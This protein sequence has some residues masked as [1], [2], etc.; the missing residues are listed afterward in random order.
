[1]SGAQKSDSLARKSSLKGQQHQADSKSTPEDANETSNAK[2]AKSSHSPVKESSQKAQARRQRSVGEGE[3]LLRQKQEAQRRRGY[4]DAALG[5]IGLEQ[6]YSREYTNGTASENDNNS[7]FQPSKQARCRKSSI[8]DKDLRNTSDNH[9][10]DGITSHSDQA[11]LSVGSKLDDGHKLESPES[12]TS[13][14]SERNNN[15]EQI[16]DSD[17]GRKSDARL[18][19]SRR[20]MTQESELT[21]RQSIGLDQGD[22]AISIGSESLKTIERPDEHNHEDQE[23]PVGSNSSDRSQRE[24]RPRK[25]SQLR[26]NEQDSIVSES[27]SGSS[28]LRQRMAR[29]QPPR[30]SNKHADHAKHHTN[31]PRRLAKTPDKS[32]RSDVFDGSD[33]S[34]SLGCA[35]GAR[36]AISVSPGSLG[37]SVNIR[38]ILENVAQDEG[39][40]Q[41]PQLAFR[42]AMDALNSNCWSTKV[43]GILALVRLASHHAQLL[44]GHQ[45]EVVNRLAD[46]TRNLRSTVSRSA[47]FALG[48]FCAKLGRSIEPELDLI[49]QA[50]LYKS[51]ENTAFIREDIRRA[52]TTMIDHVTHWKIA[53]SLINH[54]S[55]HKNLHV[56]RMASQYIA[57]VAQKMGAAKCLVGAKDIS[58]Q[59]L[60]AAAKFVQ[61]GSPHTRYYGRLI[62]STVM[63]HGAF[64]RLMRKTLTPSLYRGTLGIMESVKRRG[65]GEP[66]ADL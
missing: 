39:P 49:V 23:E 37:G 19:Q 45:H 31:T 18:I 63:Q 3:R 42:V 35:G 34:N 52:F 6:V 57:L 22:S 46:E 33:S 41:E 10:E 29:S 14:P 44:I 17:R 2:L 61:D 15:D 11:D 21:N 9:N 47:I 32:T 12:R 16:K 56:R 4:S 62:L 48:D 60:P 38:H 65:A 26:S 53:L 59:L 27:G 43:E 20:S 64:D 8:V 13:Y 40:F 51:M 54:G 58:T 1:M 30:R 7:Q 24:A 5:K 36:R 50:L 28:D 66:P 25:R 55:T